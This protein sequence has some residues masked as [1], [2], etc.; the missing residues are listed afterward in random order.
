[1]RRI[2]LLALL[3]PGVAAADI[4]LDLRP[5]PELLQ[6]EPVYHLDRGSSWDKR[7]SAGIAANVGIGFGRYDGK[8]GLVGE[9]SLLVGKRTKH[10][11]LAATSELLAGAN[12]LVRGRHTGLLEFRTD[13]RGPDDELS[14]I[15]TVEANVEHGLARTL[16]PVY[17]GPG[18]RNHGEG[19]AT[20]LIGLPPDK[21]EVIFGAL[22]VAD[23]SVTEWT[24]APLL[25]RTE[26]GAFGLGLS[27][28]PFDGELPRGR[29]DILRARVEHANIHRTLRAAGVPLRDTQVRSVEVM[30]GMHDFTAWIDHEALFVLSAEFGGVWIESDAATGTIQDT[31]FKMNTGAHFKW[32]AGSRGRREVGLAWGREPQATPD[33]QLTA[34]DWRLEMV[35]GAEDSRLVLAA[36]GGLSWVTHHSGGETDPNTMLRYGSHVEGF[37]KLGL[38]LEL[39]AY[40]SMAYEPQVA[41]DP[42]S[43]PR[44]FVTELGVL[45]RW[46]PS[47][48]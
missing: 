16:A 42:W 19:R 33:G 46:R 41:G 43:T 24:D 35:G 40:H 4:H 34:T 20:A 8:E 39:G 3:A 29:F 13:D 11:T 38:G 28:A 9:G 26:R 44:Q 21:D 47:T 6:L 30:T 14:G 10:L 23:G 1:M 25:D 45:A 37:A 17:L 18:K 15:A 5:M 32:R 2:T 31:F 48:Y 36:R 7:S 12:D 22:V 27:V